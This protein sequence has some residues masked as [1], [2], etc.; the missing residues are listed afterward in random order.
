MDC[1]DRQ[2]L[3]QGRK[4]RGSAQTLGRRTNAGMADLKSAAGKRLQGKHRERQGVVSACLYQAIY[5]TVGQHFID[6]WNITSGSEVM[7]RSR[8]EDHCNIEDSAEFIERCNES[9]VGRAIVDACYC[10][11]WSIDT[12]LLI[13]HEERHASNW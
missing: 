7:C 8:A 11:G 6:F 1:R 5:A 4:V 10:I 9:D 12:C 2:T 3:R 13:E